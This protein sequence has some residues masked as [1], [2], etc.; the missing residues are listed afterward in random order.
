MGI[1][2]LLEPNK[3]FAILQPARP[4]ITVSEAYKIYKK[5]RVDMDDRTMTFH[6]S[7]HVNHIPEL[8]S[9]RNRF[10]DFIQQH[11]VEPLLDYEPLEVY[12]L[13]HIKTASCGN[14]IK[15]YH[16]DPWWII[17]AVAGFNSPSTCILRNGILQGRQ[18]EGYPRY[19]N[20]YKSYQNS[21]LIKPKPGSVIV[22]SGNHRQ[23]SLGIPATVHSTPI[24]RSGTHRVFLHQVLNRLGERT[25]GLY[26][27]E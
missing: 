22:F 23:N 17:A 19:L 8:Q 11:V 12:G 4:I 14:S 13:P 26:K 16:T 2:D 27:I 9:V 7:N 25:K 10:Q 1:F 6:Y 20:F 15:E 18:K 21:W 24:Y 5:A 3:G